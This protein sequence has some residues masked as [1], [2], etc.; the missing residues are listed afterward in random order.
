V[1]VL[2]VYVGR[3][4][5]GRRGCNRGAEEREDGKEFDTHDENLDEL[6]RGTNCL[7]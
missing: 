3:G 2:G 4:W 7:F 5:G 6:K 1:E